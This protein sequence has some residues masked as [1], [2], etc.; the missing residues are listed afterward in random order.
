MSLNES[1]LQTSQTITNYSEESML[2]GGVSEE[3]IS[4][5]TSIEIRMPICTST[6]IR[7]TVSKNIVT[8]PKTKKIRSLSNKLYYLKKKIFKAI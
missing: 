5:N 8:T 2:D 4:N 6:P 1:L 7:E 3:A